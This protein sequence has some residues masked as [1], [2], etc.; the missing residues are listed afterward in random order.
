MLKGAAQEVVVVRPCNYYENWRGALKTMLED[1]P[2]LES[3]FSPPD[4]EIPMVREAS[5][6]TLHPLVTVPC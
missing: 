5:A 2:T 1:P 6:F 4:F 3:T